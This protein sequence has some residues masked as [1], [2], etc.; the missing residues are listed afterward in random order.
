MLLCIS[1]WGQIKQNRNSRTSSPLMNLLAQMLKKMCNPKRLADCL[2]LKTK[3]KLHRV[4]NLPFP[5][6]ELSYCVAYL[7]SLVMKAYKE[8]QFLYCTSSTPHK[9]YL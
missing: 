2:K 5:V 3:R 9:I 1:P 4:N 7:I 6:G 8:E